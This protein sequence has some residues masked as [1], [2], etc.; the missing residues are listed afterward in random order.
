MNYTVF[1][2]FQFSLVIKSEIGVGN[3][4][5]QLLL[6]IQAIV[7]QR[8]P[9]FMLILELTV[10]KDSLMLPAQYGQRYLKLIEQLQ[11]LPTLS[12]VFISN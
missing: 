7:A 10:M 5:K 11:C 8:L 2:S 4:A 9:V 1:L 12:R 3:H 6:P